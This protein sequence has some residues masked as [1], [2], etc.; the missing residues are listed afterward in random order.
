M[1]AY[2]ILIGIN[3][4]IW[5]V[6]VYLN[7]KSKKLIQSVFSWVWHHLSPME[8]QKTLL[9]G[10]WNIDIKDDSDICG[11]LLRSLN[12]LSGMI[13]VPPSSPTRGLRTLSFCILGSG[14]KHICCISTDSI[15]DHKSIL[16][17]I[18][19][20]LPT[21]RPTIIIPNRKLAE[22][23]TLRCL[24]KSQCSKDFLTNLSIGH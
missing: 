9:I 11:K 3:S 15:S 17:E 4:Y 1:N 2:K 6:N 20:S 14:I 10:D 16:L 23:I 22:D 18:S 24:N 12:K 13:I 21:K 7:R 5:I 8:V 19:V